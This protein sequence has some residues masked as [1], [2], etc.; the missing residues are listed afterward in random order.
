M[1]TNKIKI[2]ECLD[3]CKVGMEECDPPDSDVY[4]GWVEA[5]EYIL[6]GK[7]EDDYPNVTEDEQRLFNVFGYN[8]LQDNYYKGDNGLYSTAKAIEMVDSIEGYSSLMDGWVPHD[9]FLSYTED[10]EPVWIVDIEFGRQDD[11]YNETHGFTIGV[12]KAYVDEWLRRGWDQK[13]LP[14]WVENPEY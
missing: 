7:E 4:R 1:R 11:C 14:S 5:L 2:Q 9:T 10:E 3:D 6:N 13:V 8:Y 12:F